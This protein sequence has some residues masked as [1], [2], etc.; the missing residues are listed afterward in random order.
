MQHILI[1]EDD[2]AFGTMLQTWL[3]RKGFE[4]EKATSVGAAVKLLTETFGKEVDLVLSDLRLPDHD[5]LR[6]LAWMHEHDI[7]A[8][9]IVMTNYAEVQNAVLAMKSGA[10]DY[11]AKPVQPD[12][13]LQKIKDAIEQ[14]AQQSNATTQNSTT[15]NA[16]TAHNSKFKTQ[17]AKLTAPRHIEG[18]SE[19]SRQLYSYVELV[20]PTPMS[21]LILGA[22]GT[23]KEYVAH[24]IHD[25]SARA[26]RPF[27]ALD[28]GAIPRD[29]AASEFFGHKKGAFTGADTDKRGAFEMANGG[30]LFLDEVGNLSY[31][32]QVQLLRALQERR[33]RPVGGTQEIPIDIRL[34][35][36][37]NENLEEAVGEGRF[38]E[39]LYH[40]IN[41]FTIYMPK[42]SERGSDLFLFADLF[43]HHAN[44]E[45]NR[46]VEGF[47]SAAAELLASHSWPGN[48]RELNNVVKRAVLLTRGNKITTAELTQAMGQIR[49]DNV[50]QLHD[51]DTERQRIITAL[52]QTNGNKAKAARLLGVDRKTIYNKIEKLGI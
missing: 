38:R 2:I 22:S 10:A 25:L 8:P 24:R 9:F 33:I 12:I 47:D 52:Q 41:E 4:V 31:E 43:I 51:E 49:T 21:V 46:T 19:A 1:V 28:C 48:L 42:L 16:P 29:V 23:G 32:V 26:D 20:A 50:L 3:R 30:T 7:N 36:A 35:C 27:F 18:K 39:D 14:N 15:Q 17:S 34:V 5:G 44:E 40:R 13:L 6:L 37:T 45:L 11:I